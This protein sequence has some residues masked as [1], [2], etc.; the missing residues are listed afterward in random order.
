MIT[1]LIAWR[2]R[3]SVAPNRSGVNSGSSGSGP[4]AS[5]Y[6]RHPLVSSN[7]SFPSPTD[8]AVDELPAIVE[9]RAQNRVTSLLGRERAVVHDERA[10]HPRLHHEPTL[11]EVEHGVLGAPEHGA[12]RRAAQVAH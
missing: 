3:T 5:V 4:I 7:S 2:E 8:V 11:A 6:R 9:R 12:H 1:F 10:G